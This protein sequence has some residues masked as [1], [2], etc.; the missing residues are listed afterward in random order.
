MLKELDNIQFLTVKEAASLMK[1]TP[2]C[3][4][5]YL[6]SSGV[7]EGNHKKRFP[8]EIYIKIGRKVLFVKSRLMD[9]LL[10]GAEMEIIENKEE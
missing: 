4:Y 6:C 10:G 9:W 1:T 3:I 7:R 2:K 8:R 5:T